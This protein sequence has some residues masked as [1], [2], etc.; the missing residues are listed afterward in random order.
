MITGHLLCARSHTDE[1]Y[2]I[3]CEPSY[4]G[5]VRKKERKRKRKKKE[6]TYPN[7]NYVSTIKP[8]TCAYNPEC[9]F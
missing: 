8:D 5:R 9:S 1:G 3:F 7:N 6:S 4:V 2:F